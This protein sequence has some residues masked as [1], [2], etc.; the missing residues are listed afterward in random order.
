VFS[1]SNYQS[2]PLVQP[3]IRLSFSVVGEGDKICDINDIF[4]IK[5]NEYLLLALQASWVTTETALKCPCLS[6]CED[7]QIDVILRRDQEDLK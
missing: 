3:F 4:C 7:I 1:K 5:N 6:G 2:K